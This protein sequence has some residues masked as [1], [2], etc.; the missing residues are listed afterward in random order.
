MP[1]LLFCLAHTQLL[2]HAHLVF[3]CIGELLGKP[4][5]DPPEE[6]VE[7]LVNLLITGAF[8]CARIFAHAHT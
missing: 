3:S 6:N 4:K 5:T 1:A 2:S 7:A 8:L